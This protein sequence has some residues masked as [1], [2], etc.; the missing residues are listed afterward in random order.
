M[1]SNHLST[2]VLHR[3]RYGEIEGEA[4]A[5]A[6]R[7]LSSCDRCQSRMQAQERERA[8]FVLQ[9]VPEAIRAIAV[10]AP[11][12]PVIGTF[13]EL[14]SMLVAL[15][16]GLALA[17][18]VPSLRGPAGAVEGDTIAFRGALPSIEAWVDR[19]TG[20]RPLHDGERLAAGDRVQISYDPH[21]APFVAL[22]GRDGSGL[23]E[24]YSDRAPTGSGLVRAPFA[25]TLDGTPGEQELFV[26]GS[27]RALREQEIEAALSVGL[28][29]VR[30]D[31]IA[32]GKQVP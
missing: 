24:I 10:P 18:A 20:P 2:L 21:E 12:A 9:P 3:I 4:L 28:P 32:I 16:A 23:V 5:A 29:G 22:A 13:R 1:T 27:P 8:T 26:I 19:G 14:S 6:K 7:H 31:R 30:V 15:A 25:L 17:L 11:R